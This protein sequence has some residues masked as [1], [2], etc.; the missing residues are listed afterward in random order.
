MTER[1]ARNE[2]A[3]FVSMGLFWTSLAL[4][5]VYC[6]FTAGCVASEPVWTL[7]NAEKFCEKH[8]GIEHY[9]RFV[10]VHCKDNTAVY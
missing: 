1:E 8:G 6:V 7:E 2:Y 4:I 10:A 3:A 9:S 5:I